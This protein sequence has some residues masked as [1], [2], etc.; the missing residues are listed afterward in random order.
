[1]NR[2]REQPAKTELAERDESYHEGGMSP[3][4]VMGLTGGARKK[5]KK[6]GSS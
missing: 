5:K 6:K 3:K 2:G 1:M 4:G